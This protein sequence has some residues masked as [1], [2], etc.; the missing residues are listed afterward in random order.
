MHFMTEMYS[1]LSKYE[2]V[3]CKSVKLVS[4]GQKLNY[5][6]EAAL[7]V[8]LVRP[9]PDHFSADRWCRFQTA[10]TV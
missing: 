1:V 2:R 9:W 3:S 7:P 10:E 4:S 8:R 6:T 5:D